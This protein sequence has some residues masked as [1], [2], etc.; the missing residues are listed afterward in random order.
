MTLRGWGES[1]GG[2]A[3]SSRHNVDPIV[4][5][6]LGLLHDRGILGEPR[7]PPGRELAQHPQLPAAVAG[8]TAHAE[9][10][11]RGIEPNR[12][13]S[14]WPEGDVLADGLHEHRVPR[15]QPESP[16]GPG[17]DRELA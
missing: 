9:A 6:A 14:H 2:I 1:S 4:R 11:V 3:A 5:L 15:S 13:S 8:L 10:T 16:I 7:C 12:H 17:W